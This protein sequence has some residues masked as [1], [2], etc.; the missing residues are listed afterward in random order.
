M[1][2]FAFIFVPIWLTIFAVLGFGFGIICAQQ[3]LEDKN[4]R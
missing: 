3:Y 4:D 2:A 1:G